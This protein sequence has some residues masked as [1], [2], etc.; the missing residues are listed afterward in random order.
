M[1]RLEGQ[2]DLCAVGT[3]PGLA[4]S[5]ASKGLRYRSYEMT[6]GVSP[7]RD[8]RA[9]SQLVRIFRAERP[10]VVHAFDTK[11]AIWGRLAARLAGVPVV[12][13]TLPGLG[14]LY[15]A[16]G[17]KARTVRLAYQ[18]LQTIACRVSDLTTFQN[19]DD[20][21]E[22]KRRRVVAAARALV[23]A[24]SG[25]R[26]DVFAPIDLESARRVRLEHGLRDEIA[27]VM[28]SRVIRSKGVLEFA[29]AA[30]VARTKSPAVRFILVGPEDR[31][32]LDALTT[33]ELEA[34][35]E[36]VTWLGPRNHVREI[37]GMADIFVFPSFYREG[38]PRALLEAASMALPLI[39]ADVPGSRDIVDDGVNGYLVP[40]R[41]PAAI[42]DAV[43][44]LAASPDLR[45]RFGEQSRKR[46]VLR[47]DLAAVAA[48]MASVY[49]ELLAVKLA[50]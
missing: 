18:P 8:L 15:A 5:F 47:F 30:R 1:E 35:R 40:P 4:A 36:S 25:V 28:V 10:A 13:G 49:H 39:A 12:I 32:S 7:L 41:D 48:R 19:E 3:L 29:A 44:R 38:V 16:P 37:L 2:F 9:V 26:T 34:V 21:R 20:A 43:L 23:I 46:A 24:G 33:T 50:S 27:V 31:A 42:V 14:S 6:R 22:F 17:W 11:P 45:L